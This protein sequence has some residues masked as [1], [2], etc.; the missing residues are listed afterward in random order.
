M[1]IEFPRFVDYK[2]FYRY[3]L[4]KLVLFTKLENQEELVIDLQHT[5]HITPNVVCD[6]L[7]YFKYQYEIKGAAV[8]L[9]FGNSNKLRNYLEDAMF[10]LHNENETLFSTDIVSYRNLQKNSK[11]LNTNKIN[12]VNIPISSNPYKH[13]ILPV[14]VVSQIQQQIYVLFNKQK[15][16]GM[17][18]FGL[19]SPE[20]LTAAF[21]E[22]VENS[23]AHS[24]DFRNCGCYYSFQNYRKTGLSFACSD[25]GIGFFESLKRKYFYQYDEYEDKHKRPKLF[26]EK[27]LLSF[28]REPKKRNIAAILESIVFWIGEDDVGY[29]GFPYIFQILVLPSNGIL[30]IHSDNT[31]LTIDRDFLYEFCDISVVENE[32]VRRFLI[33][34]FRK[35]EMRALVLNRQKQKE[36][37]DQG[38]IR[39]YEYNF[40]GVHLSVHIEGGEEND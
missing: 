2:Y 14:S 30:T 32:S 20:Q 9:A 5:D 40:P 3:I 19:E 26:S 18:R 34:G 36:K 11:E 33:K 25:I 39:F 31:L 35:E 10:F 27:E 22:I 29:F 6:L 7:C 8:F 38:T 1:V 28:E 24:N 13:A 4:E 21:K 37:I 17:K 16:N 23:Y 15:I 12:R